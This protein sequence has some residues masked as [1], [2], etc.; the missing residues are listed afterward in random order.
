MIS[1]RAISAQVI[2]YYWLDRNKTPVCVSY[3]KREPMFPLR[4]FLEIPGLVATKIPATSGR[5]FSVL[6]SYLAVL[7]CFAAGQVLGAT[8][9]VNII[10][11]AFNPAT[12]T[13]QVNDSVVWNWIGPTVH[14]STSNNGL[15]DSGFLDASDTK[16]TH[17]FTSSGS[18]PYFCTIHPFMT[19][20]VTVQNPMPVNVPPSV[21]ISSPQDGAIFPAPWTG[22]IQATVGDSDGT[23]TQVVFMA[24]STVLGAISNPPSNPSVTVSNLAAG[25]YS[26]I[27]T[28]TDNAGASTASA[29]VNITVSTGTNQPPGVTNLTVLLFGAV[30]FDPQTG[31]F[32][33]PVEVNNAG[34]SPVAGLRLAVRGLPAD[35]KLYDASGSTNGVPFVEYD[36]ALNPGASVAFLL[37]YYRSNRVEFVSTNFIAT[38]IKPSTAAAPAGQMLQLDRAPFLFN[39]ALVIEFASVPGK[40]YVVEYSADMQTWN[41]AVPPIIAAGTRVQWT[42]TGPPKTGSAPGGPGQRFY[43]V[44]QLP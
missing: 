38:A 23:V 35:V 2:D 9:N 39:G 6:A 44:L 28:A 27:V 8:A 29:T 34:D 36:Q 33:Q 17:T 31:L 10:D 32:E 40:T 11:F 43:R 24:G 14:T 18:F 42:D 15:W 1:N 3:A 41:V 4:A 30:R 25:N 26:L 22:T 19:A 5:R 16:F 13:I 7:L 37:E 20:S 21:S 12:V